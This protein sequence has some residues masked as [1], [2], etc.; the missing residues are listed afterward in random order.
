MFGLAPVW[1]CK[2]TQSPNKL[3]QGDTLS[4][5][6]VKLY[7]ILLVLF[8]TGQ[9]FKNIIVPLHTISLQLTFLLLCLLLQLLP[10]LAPLAILV[11]PCPPRTVE[12][13]SLELPGGGDK[14]GVEYQAGGGGGGGVPD[15]RSL[16]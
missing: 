2:L 15:I 10:L 8:Q 7:F 13:D 16:K 3:F 12:G 1:E 5:N 11:K 14:A 6:K 4:P 9:C